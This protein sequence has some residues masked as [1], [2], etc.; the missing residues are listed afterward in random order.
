MLMIV[1][2]YRDTMLG[3]R[4]RLKVMTVKLGEENS[5]PGR[6]GGSVVTPQVREKLNTLIDY[7]Q[8]N[9]GRPVTREDLAEMVGLSP[10]YLGRMFKA[11]TG[12]KINDYIS[13]VRIR[14]A[15]RMLRENPEAKIIDIAFVVGFESL[16]TFNRTFMKI[17]K[18][19]PTDYRQ[20]F[21]QS[22]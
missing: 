7:I 13:E 21:S 1:L 17:M 2:L 5:I 10:D 3:E 14:E 8:A 15:C 4:H 11:H 9:F 12:H 19:A 18:L 16:A 6:C 22:E 20:T